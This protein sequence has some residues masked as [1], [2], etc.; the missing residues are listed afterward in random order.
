[1]VS[2]PG[3]EPP[4]SRM[5]HLIQFRAGGEVWGPGMHGETGSSSTPQGEYLPIKSSQD[6][7]ETKGKGKGKRNIVGD[8]SEDTAQGNGGVRGSTRMAVGDTRSTP[9]LWKHWL[10]K[11]ARGAQAHMAVDLSD[12]GEFYRLL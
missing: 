12:A 7:T 4:H 5:N 10:C 8:D 3:G 6:E 11:C 9:W 2:P 1:M